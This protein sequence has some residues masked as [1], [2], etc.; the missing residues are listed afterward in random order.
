[1][2][3]GTKPFEAYVRAGAII[4]RPHRRK[5]NKKPGKILKEILTVDT[6]WKVV[7]TDGRKCEF[8]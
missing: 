4:D 5:N 1:M 3:F 7:Y 6:D 8:Q 2:C